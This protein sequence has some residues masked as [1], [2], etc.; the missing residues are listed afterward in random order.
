VGLPMVAL[1]TRTHDPQP[2][3][4]PAGTEAMLGRLCQIMISNDA[5]IDRRQVYLD[6]LTRAT[7]YA[8]D[9]WANQDLAAQIL[10]STRRS[11]DACKEQLRANRAEA[12][13][14]LARLGR[15]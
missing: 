13:A 15:S 5:I 10:D 9:P 8:T 2:R 4:R 12:L 3:P 6:R 14:I 7:E 11:L 1:A